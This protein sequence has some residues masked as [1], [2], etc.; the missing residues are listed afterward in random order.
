MALEI[1]RA[2]DEEPLRSPERQPVVS[3]FE[4]VERESRGGCEVVGPEFGIGEESRRFVGDP[5]PL[6]EPGEQPLRLLAIA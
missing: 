2:L 3:G 6:F 4:R 1:V 5:L